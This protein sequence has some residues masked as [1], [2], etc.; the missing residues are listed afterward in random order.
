MLTSMMKSKGTLE[1]LKLLFEALS[2]ILRDT[3]Y[4]LEWLGN[5]MDAMARLSARL[6]GNLEDVFGA[7]ADLPTAQPWLR[8]LADQT[9]SWNDELERLTG[10]GAATTQEMHRLAGATNEISP[11]VETLSGHAGKF[12]ENMHVWA[13][14]A[15]RAKTTTE[16]FA[17]ATNK[18]TISTRVRRPGHAA[19][20]HGVGWTERPPWMTT[21]PR[22][23]PDKATRRW[24]RASPTCGDAVQEERP[25]LERQHP[26]GRTTGSMHYRTRSA[27]SRISATRPVA[28]GSDIDAQDRVDREYDK[29]SRQAIL[30][31][32][33]GSGRD[34]GHAETDWPATIG[35][36]STS[37]RPPGAASSALRHG[38]L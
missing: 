11:A 24:R 27:Q 3:G 38:R 33:A 32:A 26:S 20:H 13:P 28:A 18:A 35:S 10:T 36:I 23:E 31:L 19:L 8:R 37:R 21:R 22:A 16:D 34:H 12:V 17:A 25:K 30:G 15:E 29:G 4:V 9:G 2:N 5:K 6:T 14:T 7:L 1:G